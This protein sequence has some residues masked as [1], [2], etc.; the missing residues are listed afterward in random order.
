MFTREWIENELAGLES[1]LAQIIVQLHQTE[2]AIQALQQMQ[3]ALNAED[4]IPLDELVDTIMPGA[5]IESIDPIAG[6]TEQALTG[7]MTFDVVI[8]DEEQE[9]DNED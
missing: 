3:G 6:Q 1:Q 5:T 4:G 8:P 9:S 2:G 7:A